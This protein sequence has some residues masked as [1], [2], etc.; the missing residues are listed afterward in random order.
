MRQALVP[1]NTLALINTF[2]F[3]TFLLFFLRF[4]AE[5][6]PTKANRSP[7]RERK[8][9]VLPRREIARLPNECFLNVKRKFAA[10]CRAW[11]C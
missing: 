5:L 9:M 6:P 11:S 7:G 2:S 1:M 4:R 10:D 3:I 8:T